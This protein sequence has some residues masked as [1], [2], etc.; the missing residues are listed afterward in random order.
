MSIQSLTNTQTRTE[1]RRSSGPRAGTSGPSFQERLAQTAAASRTSCSRESLVKEDLLAALADTKTIL[2]K[3]MKE[4]KEK[5]E[6][7]VA[8]EK[9]MEYIDAW[10]ESLREGGAS[11]D[12]VKK[13]ARAY[14]AAN[15]DPS[16][17]SAES[18]MLDRLMECFAG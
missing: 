3:Q 9:L 13:A 10:I 16:H 15:T 5:A 4:G 2:L 17:P 12:E 11:V 7:K 18:R 6:E 8:W 14:A 1:S